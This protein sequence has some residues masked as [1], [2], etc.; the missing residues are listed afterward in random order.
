MITVQGMPSAVHYGRHAAAVFHGFAFQSI[1][2]ANQLVR[3]PC[4]VNAG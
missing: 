3:E 1:E 4:S 2:G